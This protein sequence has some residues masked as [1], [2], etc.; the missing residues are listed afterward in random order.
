MCSTSKAGVSPIRPCWNAWPPRSPIGP[1]DDGF[2]VAPGI[3]LANRR[4]SIVGLADGA[5]P[6]FNEDQSVAVVC[7]GELFEFPE[8]RAELEA[9]GHVFRT[10]SDVEIIVHLYEEYGEGF[11]ER[12]TG[13]FAFALVDFKRRIVLLARDRVGICPLFWSRQG[14]FLYFG[15]EIK[16]LLASGGVTPKADTRGLDHLFTFFALGGRRTAFDGVQALAP[17]HYLKIAWG[18]DDKAATPVE[19]KYWDFDFPDW[20]EEDDP[21]DE[22]AAIDAFEEAFARAVEIRLRADVPVVGYLSGGVDSAYVLATAAR[23]AGKPLPSFTLR[24][25]DPRLDETTEALE[26]SGAI[27]GQ[28]T[29]VEACAGIITENYAA[30]TTAAECPV[31]DTSCAA[32]L[33]LSR[34]VRAQGYKVVLTGEG[35]DE[36]FAGYVWYKIR[37]IARR[38]DVGDAFRPSTAISRAARK[39][40]ARD[41]SFAELARIDG[42]IGG[43]HAQSILYNLVARSRGRYYS[44]GMKEEIGAHVAYEDLDLDT[45]R[46]ARWHPLNRSLYLGYKVHLSGLLLGPKRPGGNGEQRGDALPVPR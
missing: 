9:K 11:I 32:L 25:P 16:A 37:E 5:Q 24:V 42:M 41:Q 13:Q 22:E 14:D 26:A 17:G 12:L 29:V 45:E 35:A 30:L 8:W 40:A 20:G 39:W 44:A 23:I 7:N 43:P 33:A 28:S 21:S 10:H 3:G 34:E 31:L 2:L 46:M 4:L 18:G 38:L 27:G 36:A 6:I 19:T 1:D 15:S